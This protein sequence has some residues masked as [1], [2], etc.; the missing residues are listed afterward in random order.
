MS[1]EKVP[2]PVE[3]EQPAVVEEPKKPAPAK[4]TAK[5]AHN[6]DLDDDT[7]HREYFIPPP[8]YKKP[9]FPSSF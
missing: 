1:E 7:V 5:K 3:V 8:G 2:A 9:N 6:F 4:K